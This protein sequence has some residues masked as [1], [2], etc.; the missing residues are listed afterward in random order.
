MLKIKTMKNITLATQS[1]R[2][3]EKLDYHLKR[4]LQ[5]NLGEIQLMIKEGSYN[6]NKYM[7]LLEAQSS[8]ANLINS[9]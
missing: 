6:P 2:I 5:D 1:I 7:A 3:E 9:L 4:R 8:I